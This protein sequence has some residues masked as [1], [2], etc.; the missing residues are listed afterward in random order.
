MSLCLALV[1]A[2]LLS[3]SACVKLTGQ[4]GKNFLL[5]STLGCGSLADMLLGK[6]LV[7]VAP[8]PGGGCSLTLW[9]LLQGPVVEAA[10]LDGGG[11]CW[12][13]RLLLLGLVVIAPGPSSCCSWV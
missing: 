10:P 13:W 2:I 7:L 5:M 9:W 4:G 12:A 3:Y 8:G 1:V 11:Y 6:G